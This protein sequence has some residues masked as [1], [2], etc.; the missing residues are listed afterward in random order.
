MTEYSLAFVKSGNWWTSRTQRGMVSEGIKLHAVNSDFLSFV[1]SERGHLVRLSAA[2]FYLICLK[3]LPGAIHKKSS[4]P[5][6]PVPI[7]TPVVLRTVGLCLI[8]NLM[9]GT[10]TLSLKNSCLHKILHT[11][12]LGTRLPKD[13]MHSFIHLF[14]HSLIHSFIRLLW[15]RC[16]IRYWRLMNNGLCPRG[17]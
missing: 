7:S 2:C 9:K 11:I 14:A 15:A 12:S 4:S 13:C 8:D 17:A 1:P 16:R 3:Y 6:H 10:W 5:P